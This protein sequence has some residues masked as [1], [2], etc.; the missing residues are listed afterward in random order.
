MGKISLSKPLFVMVYGYPGSGKTHF[1]R[2]L[3][4]TLQA[5]HVYSDRIRGELFT[6][7]QYDKQENEVVDHLMR[8]M[9]EEFLKAGVSVVFDTDVSRLAT[10]RELRNMTRQAKID[11][12]LVWL[13]IDAES[14]FARLN[15]RDKRTTEDKYSAPYDRQRFDDI[16]KTMQN[17]K[18]EDY[19]VVSGKHTY[20]TQRSAVIKKLYEMGVIN[21]NTASSSVIKPGLVN[22]VPNP[23]AG[24]VDSS[25]RNIVIR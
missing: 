24:R 8:Y 4:Q 21:P 11:P 2:Q 14:S 17:P 19:I 25:R 12:L 16:L 22:L 15:G 5:A 20:N 13:Q 1:S 23:M 9:A 6:K 7:P 3:S 18:D 10:R